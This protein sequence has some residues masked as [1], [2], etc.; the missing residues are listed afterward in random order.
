MLFT[1]SSNKTVLLVHLSVGNRSMAKRRSVKTNRLI[2][3]L[4]LP[5]CP[6]GPKR[7]TNSLAKHDP[8]ETILHARQKPAKRRFAVLWA[9]GCTRHASPR[10]ASFLAD[11]PDK[12][13]ITMVENGWCPR[14]E[15]RP[16]DMPSFARRPWRCHSQRY[17]N[18]SSM[19]AEEV[20]LWK[21]A[22]CPNFADAHAGCDTYS[23][24]NVDRLHQPLMDLFK[25][26]T[27]E[28]IVC[29]LKDI[30]C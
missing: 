24:M 9:D 25:N 3:I 28:W 27:W 17:L 19:A 21:F 1:L 11:H 18:L 23:C 14:C 7:H 15:I 16:D 26:H 22:N 30:Y 20:G 6:N 4:H 13:T 2:L 10:I 8:I 29:F 12:W 5:N